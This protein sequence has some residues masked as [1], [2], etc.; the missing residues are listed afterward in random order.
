M[1]RTLT[2][3]NRAPGRAQESLHSTTGHKGMSFLSLV[4]IL[5]P[6]LAEEGGVYLPSRVLLLLNLVMRMMVSHRDGYSQG[7]I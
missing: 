4:C 6:P 5:P 3:G 7:G 1:K 2:V